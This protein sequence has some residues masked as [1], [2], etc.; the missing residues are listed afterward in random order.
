MRWMERPADPITNNNVTAGWNEKFRRT[1]S[2]AETAW[3]PLLRG[4]AAR[5][6]RDLEARNSVA[7]SIV[8]KKIQI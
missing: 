5:F 2:C 3:A 8:G 7:A 4:N 1:F 6:V